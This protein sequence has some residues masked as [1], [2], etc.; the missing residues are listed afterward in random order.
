[1]PT[2]TTGFDADTAGLI[3]DLRG[4]YGG[5]H[6]ALSTA[7]GLCR[8]GDADALE[9][10]CLSCVAYVLRELG[11]WDAS[12]DLCRELGAGDVRPVAR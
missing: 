6:E 10:G 5:A 2:P 12:V 4:S 11:D 8:T 1:M 9:H 7:V 3:I